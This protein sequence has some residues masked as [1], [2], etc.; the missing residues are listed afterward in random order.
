MTTQLSMFLAIA[1]KEFWQ[2]SRDRLTAIL[3]LSV[4]IAQILIFGFAIELA[5]KHW[6]GVWVQTTSSALSASIT[7]EDKILI[8]NI[9]VKINESTLVSLPA[10]PVSEKAAKDAL[11]SGQAC[12]ILYVPTQLSQY[13]MQST[14]IPIKLVTDISDPYVSSSMTAIISGIQ[15]PNNLKNAQ[16]KST[17]YK[18][19]ITNAIIPIELEVE[20]KFGLE[21]R[22]GAYLVPALT[23]VIL[24]LTL[25]LLAAFSLVRERE[26]GTWDSLLSTPAGAGVIIFGKLV[27]YAGL[28]LL[29]FG[30]MQVLAHVL[31][32]TPIASWMQWL[33]VCFFIVGVLGLGAAISLLARTQMQAMQLGVFFYLPSILLSG[34]MFPFHAM[35]QWARWIGEILPLTHFLRVLRSDLFRHAPNYLLMELMWPIMIFAALMMIIS[36]FFY[37]RR[38]R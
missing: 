32:N 38:I 10:L 13:A 5:P 23:G 15:Q 9:V 26:R 2:L 37:S 14:P 7:N 30:L 22:S 21:N 34:F 17:S 33:A 19:P 18:L 25:I 4:P 27:P 31:F 28:G 6:P 1:K 16:E 8:N 12:F 11:L 29:L 20:P 24:T 3:L 35:P 36:V